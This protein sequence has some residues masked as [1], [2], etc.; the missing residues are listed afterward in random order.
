VPSAQKKHSCCGRGLC[1]L[2]PAG[3]DDDTRSDVTPDESA[4]TSSAEGADADDNIIADVSA[5]AESDVIAFAWP[6]N[7]CIHCW[8]AKKLL[9]KTVTK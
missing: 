6:S 1:V 7:R 3:E 9:K 2:I 4:A 8:P 5:T